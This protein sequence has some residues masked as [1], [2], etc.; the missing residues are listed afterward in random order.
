MNV[1]IT[2]LNLVL[3]ASLYTSFSRKFSAKK[4]YVN[5]FWKSSD[6]RPL[7]YLLILLVLH[8]FHYTGSQFAKSS[9]WQLIKGK[10]TTQKNRRK[11]LV[12]IA[13]TSIKRL[14]EKSNSSSLFSYQTLRSLQL[15]W[16]LEEL[17]IYRYQDAINENLILDLT[18]QISLP[19][20]LAP[21]PYV[22]PGYFGNY[23]KKFL[24]VAVTLNSFLNC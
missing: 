21:S 15:K 20:A 24:I 19:P 23:Q 16:L 18:D 8:K 4:S 5:I 12:L 2:N 11:I 10:S 14:L 17:R 7:N 22:P 1:T 13:M 9:W 6:Q 3:T